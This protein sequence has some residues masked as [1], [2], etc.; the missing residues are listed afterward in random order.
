MA[1]RID[2]DQMQD[3]R[4]QW[5]ADEDARLRREET[6][7]KLWWMLAL[8]LMLAAFIATFALLAAWD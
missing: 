7:R 4:A 1:G 2:Q 3:L 6:V 5:Q 8:V